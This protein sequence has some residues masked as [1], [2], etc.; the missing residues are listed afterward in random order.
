M[1]LGTGASAVVGGDDVSQHHR[2]LNGWRWAQVRRQVLARAG[3]RCEIRNPQ[4]CTVVATQV[5]HVL[6][7]SEGGDPY[8]MRW[9]RAACR[10]CNSARNRTTPT[11]D[12]GWRW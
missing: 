1:S 7:L 12:D 8:D 9:L 4:V 3:G 11:V 2:R 5:D 10:Q 6:P